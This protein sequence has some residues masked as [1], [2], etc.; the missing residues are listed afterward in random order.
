MNAFEE[1]FTYE[2]VGAEPG[3]EVGH[4]GMTIAFVGNPNCGK[5]TLFNAYTGSNLKTANWPG[6]TVEGKEGSARFEGYEVRLVDL[7]G[8]YSLTSYTM[9]EEVARNYVLSGDADVI[10]DVVDA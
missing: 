9:E 5:T 10:I 1:H 6:V 3:P 4:P 8:T 7:P 2:P